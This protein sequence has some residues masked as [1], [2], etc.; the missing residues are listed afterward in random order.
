VPSQAA[1]QPKLAYRGIWL[2]VQVPITAR[3]ETPRDETF[4]GGD[5]V[6]Y[7]LVEKIVGHMF[8]LSGFSVSVSVSV[9]F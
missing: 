7:L 3:Y 2:Q 6:P 4:H 8:R 5:K 9:P 1:E